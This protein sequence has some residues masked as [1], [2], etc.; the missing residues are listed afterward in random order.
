MAYAAAHEIGHLLLGDRHAPAGIM[1][2]VWGK[3]EFRDMA[4]LWL[5][6]RAGEREALREAVPTPERHLAG[7]Q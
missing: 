5:D 4:R 3:P 6:F 2:A 1:R 7:L